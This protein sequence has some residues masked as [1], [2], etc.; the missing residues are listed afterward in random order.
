MVGLRVEYQTTMNQAFFI[1]LLFISTGASHGLASTTQVQTHTL[2]RLTGCFSRELMTFR[3]RWDAGTFQNYTRPGELQLFYMLT[4]DSIWHECP[5]YNANGE[6]ECYFDQSHTIIWYSYG[7]QL[8]SR[9]HNIT[10]D[11]L[12]FNV[13][14]IVYPDPPVGLNWTLLTVGQTGLLFDVMVSWNPPVS[15]ADNVKMGWM[16]LVYETEYREKNGV[17]WNSIDSGRS[18]KAYIYALHSNTEY[19][20]RVRCGMDGFNF[21]N[22][23]DSIFIKIPSKESSIPFAAVLS[24]A[25]IGIALIVMLIVVSRQQKLYVVFLPPVPGPKIKG[26]DPECLQKGKLTELTSILATH[27]DLRPE[28]YGS[29]PWVEFIE[30]DIEEPNEGIEDFHEHLLVADSPTS[31]TSHISSGFRDDDS[32]R[33]SCCDPDL[34]DPYQ[35]DLPHSTVAGSNCFETSAPASSETTMQPAVP[36]VQ[37]T[38]WASRGLYSQVNDVTISGEIVLSSDE[39]SKGDEAIGKDQALRNKDNIK[40]KAQ[41]LS[42]VT[43]DGGDYTSEFDISKI[44]TQHASECSSEA[45]VREC[46]QPHEGYHNTLSETSVL[47]SHSG[48][49]SHAM[50][51]SPEYTMVDGVDYQNSLLLKPNTPVA[52]RPSSVKTLPIPQGYLTPDLLESVAP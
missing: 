42:V 50:P 23:S 1:S 36:A 48:L 10:H 5:S 11:E 14:N 25:V 3:C 39:Q 29:D 2:P 12:Y 46:D 43:A 40:A 44:N 9:S 18:T 19:E 32:G 7:I 38:P 6:N 47:P 8:R 41:Q 21:G 34:H 49:Q 28:L 33:A 35:T 20:I 37:E 24:I 17:K 52:T 13:E 15:A 4:K 22:F 31:G 26:I 16:S 45:N 30:V 51:P 27:P